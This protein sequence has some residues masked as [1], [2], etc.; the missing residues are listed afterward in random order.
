LEPNRARVVCVAGARPNFMKVA[1]ILE[2]IRARDR[3]DAILIHTGQ[4]YDEAMSDSFFRDLG[5]PVPDVSLGVGSDTPPRQ[6]ARILERIEPQLERIRPSCLIVVGD[7]NST[8]AGALAAVKMGIPLAH[9]EAGLRSRDR[10]MPEELNR[11]MTDACSD[12][13]FTTERDASQNLRREGIDPKRIHFAGNVMIDTLRRFE[14]KARDS[15]IVGDLRLSVGG[16]SLI[17]LHRP[18][19]VDRR[20]DLDR[21]VAILDGTAS[22]LPI[23]FPVHPRTRARLD[24]AGVLARLAEN[25]RMRVIPPVGYIDFLRLMSAARIVMTDSGGI[26]EET[27]VLGVPCLTLR[28]NTERPITIS[29][30][31]NRLV[32]S[33]PTRVLAALDEEMDRPP[34][35]SPR[36]PELWDGRAAER[37]VAILEREYAR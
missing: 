5:I 32:G 27:T 29:E 26:Q 6:I 18:S 2:S 21:I 12:L 8:L 19:N 25:P 34:A 22:R 35:E 20:E 1:P 15:A 24:E 11:I 17:T 23:V 28:D 9:V 3:L 31:T 16:Y 33:S 36:S 14:A 10:T 4:H 7:V 30:G 13:L 37:I